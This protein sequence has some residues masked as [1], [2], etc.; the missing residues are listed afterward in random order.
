MMCLL[1]TFYPFLINSGNVQKLRENIIFQALCADVVQDESEPGTKIHPELN[2][3]PAF[4]SD[5]DITAVFYHD[6]NTA[7]LYAY[8]KKYNILAVS[9]DGANSW[10]KVRDFPYIVNSFVPVPGSQDS[11]YFIEQSKNHLAKNNFSVISDPFPKIPP[12][13]SAIYLY[14][15]DP[16]IIMT[17]NNGDLYRSVDGGMNWLSMK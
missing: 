6:M 2:E 12:D 11:F 10:Q 7:K 15:K 5:S 17:V 4:Q 13:I 14:D 16:S 1:D 3:R 9:T 8:D